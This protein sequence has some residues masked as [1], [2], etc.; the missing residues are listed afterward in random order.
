MIAADLVAR[1]LAGGEMAL[2][3]QAPVVAETPLARTS[4]RDLSGSLLWQR[5]SCDGGQSNAACK[6][7]RP[8]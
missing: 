7:G 8:E 3:V 5:R 2:R 1:A 4:S 6:K